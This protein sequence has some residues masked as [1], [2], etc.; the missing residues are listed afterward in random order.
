M[1]IDRAE[2]EDVE[3][4]QPL[5]AGEPEGAAESVIRRTPWW[6]LST[7]IHVVVALMLGWFWVVQSAAEEEVTVMSPPRKPR[8]TPV[9]EPPKDQPEREKILDIVKQSQDVVFMKNVPE[10]T[11][12]ETPDDEEF[13]KAKGES[14]DFVSDKPFK[15]RGTYDVVGGGGGGGGKF[16]GRLGGKKLSVA[17]G[18]GGPKTEDAVLEAL[19]W[20]ARH[21][22]PDGSWNVSGYVKQCKATCSPNPGDEEFDA[23]VTGLSLLAFLGAGFSHLSKDTYDGICFGDVVRKGVQWMM[24]HQDPEGCIGSR[25]AHKYMYNHTICA[26]ALTEA[27]GLTGSNLFRDQAQKAVD[28][29]IAA[30][31]PG[32]GWRY[33]YKCG[34]N[35]SSVTGWAVMVLKSA[36]I[37]ALNVPGSGYQGTRAWYDSVTDGTYGRVG[38]NAP[39]TGKVFIPGKNE[40]FDH[41]EALTAIAVMS[42]IFID[43]KQNDPRLANGCELLLRDKPVWNGNA[44]DFYYVYY[45]SLAL[46][47]YDGPKGPKW[48][49]WNEPMKNMLVENQNPKTAPCRRGSWEPV[50][51]W[52]CEGGR[53]YATAINALTLEVYYRYTNVFVGNSR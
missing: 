44:T 30:Q 33:S 16:G 5:P 34:D 24:S 32:M 10:D 1:H 38:Y 51:R 6:S 29:V 45:A 9:M 14:F 52:S 28:F 21:Q 3:S 31:N 15:G 50:D 8:E 48:S 42:R 41:H 36:E 22:S 11:T 20:L 37:S 4:A 26:L 25:N 2:D 40:H 12:T 27:F 18:G 35:D 23:G 49:S 17:N 19:R 47:Q 39:N 53:V 46:F 7:G 43:R 13:K